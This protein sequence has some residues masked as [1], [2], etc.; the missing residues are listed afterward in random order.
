VKR[1]TKKEKKKEK[2]PHQSHTLFWSF[3]RCSAFKLVYSNCMW[4]LFSWFFWCQP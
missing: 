2:K 1:K 4:F 3:N